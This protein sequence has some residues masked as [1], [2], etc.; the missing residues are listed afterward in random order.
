M[1]RGFTLI[2][3]LVA[4]TILSLATALVFESFV[5][6]TNT[7]DIAREEAARLRERQYIWRNFSE[8]MNAIYSDAACQIT[9]FALLGEDG[10][11]PAGPGDSLSFCTSLPMPGSGALPGQL[12]GVSYSVVG[13]DEADADAPTAGFST[14]P[15]SENYAPAYLLIVESPVV[16]ESDG[17]SVDEEAED[18]MARVRQVPITSMDI[19]YYDNE[20]E[21]WVDDW[22][23]IEQQRL[24]WAI[25]VM[26][27]LARTGDEEA[28]LDADPNE[29]DLDMTFVLPLGAG[30]TEQFI[31]PN[32][33]YLAPGAA[34]ADSIFNEDP[35]D[36]AKSQ[37]RNR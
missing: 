1:R 4:I 16:H 15:G 14:D 21:E 12:R 28:A 3:I 7:T 37:R 27:T 26:I 20:T 36:R 25:E 34:S 11:G 6:V 24:P 32:H 33:F 2:E 8:N 18:E 13:P 19:L 29:P 10:A 5:S 9:E 30:T 17:V 22:D 23:S 31:D 35:Q